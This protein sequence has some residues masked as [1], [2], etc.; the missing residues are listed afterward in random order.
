MA[1]HDID[2]R[3]GGPITGDS[4][5]RGNNLPGITSIKP[6]TDG[7]RAVAANFDRPPENIRQRTEELRGELEAQKYLQDGDMKWIL[8]SGNADGFHVPPASWPMIEEWREWPGDPTHRWYFKLTP[9]VALVVQP[10]NT[11]PQGIH[12]IKFWEFPDAANGVQIEMERWAYSE[13]NIREVIWEALP[14]AEIVGTHGTF[15]WVDLTLSGEDGHILTITI[16]D[17]VTKTQLG[18]L[19][20]AFAVWDLGYLRPAGFICTAPGLATNPVDIA[21]IPPADVDYVFA[22]TFEREL[23]YITAETLWDF[24][25]AGG[26]AFPN[27]M[28]DGDTLA[29]MWEYFIDPAANTGRRQAIMENGNTEVLVPQLFLASLHPEWIPLA[30]PLCKRINK[31]L[32]WLDGTIA[33]EGMVWPIRFGE[34][35]YTVERIFAVPTSVPISMTSMWY[36]AAVPPAWSTIQDALDGIVSDLAS[37]AGTSGADCIGVAA[38]AVMPTSRGYYNV[39]ALGDSVQNTVIGILDV[40]DTKG[41]LGEGPTFGNEEVVTGRWLFNNHVRIGSNRVVLRAS[42]SD[43][44]WRPVYRNGGRTESGNDVDWETCTVYEQ[45]NAAGFRGATLRVIGGYVD[46][47]SG[48]I[49]T[50]AAGAGSIHY[51][52]TANGSPGGDV[53]SAGY[54][55]SVTAPAILD[56]TNPADWD[57]YQTRSV[58]M[59]YIDDDVNGTAAPPGP[60]RVVARKIWNI[61][62]RINAPVA[63][64]SVLYLTD[65]GYIEGDGEANPFCL[66]TLFLGAGAFAP[67]IFYNDQLL[68]VVTNAVYDNSLLNWSS[69]SNTEC[70]SGWMILTEGGPLGGVFQLHKRPTASSWLLTDWDQSV[71][72]DR[73]GVTSAT[74]TRASLT[75]GSTADTEIPDTIN[76]LLV[77]SMTHPVGGR[78]TAIFRVDGA[79]TELISG[80]IGPGGVPLPIWRDDITVPP[81]PDQCFVHLNGLSH[82]ITI[83]N[84]FLA[85]T[86]TAITVGTYLGD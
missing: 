15:Q 9:G 35:G 45:V 2:F 4:G 57:Y 42:P 65:L 25:N 47:I 3:Q 10:S 78:R 77:V 69:I 38:T 51:V 49:R 39:P 16:R 32:V 70:S 6:Y 40:L 86:L 31:E 74:F 34:N 82:T 55:D 60:G 28:S 73:T 79:G 61:T 23:H 62:Q 56:I 84:H 54:R 43:T 53:L 14:P 20:A 80:N 85:D 33:T 8:G 72:L 7:E 58:G 36:G 37:A 64:N 46:P 81:V 26:P 27:L 76:G 21:T 29:V 17:D 30:I 1:K 24:F 44:L 52:M 66:N 68:F 13:A 48:H 19:A 22:G 50:P 83:T 18:H 63:L 12:E 5:E 41:T 11:P 59:G 67:S 75:P 71:R